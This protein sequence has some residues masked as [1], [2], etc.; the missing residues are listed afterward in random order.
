MNLPQ[1]HK[2]CLQRKE[3][4]Y[5]FLFRF[6]KKRGFHVLLAVMRIDAFSVII[7]IGLFWRFFILFTFSHVIYKFGNHSF[8]P[9]PGASYV[10][11]RYL[12]K[13]QS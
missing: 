8:T 1:N 3:N 11:V 5:V 4:R 6:N 2:S 13:L 12:P 7:K 9:H 10:S